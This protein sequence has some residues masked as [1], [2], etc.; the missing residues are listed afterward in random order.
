MQVFFDF[1][2]REEAQKFID[3]LGPDESDLPIQLG[4]MDDPS[5]HV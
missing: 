4:E 1:P 3:G 2:T 5:F